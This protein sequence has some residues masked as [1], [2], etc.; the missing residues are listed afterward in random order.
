MRQNHNRI[1]DETDEKNQYALLS[2]VKRQMVHKKQ[3]E[4]L[5]WTQIALMWFLWQE[6]IYQKIK[7]IQPF[8]SRSCIMPY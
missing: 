3:W 7:L 5:P 4:F 6:P 8:T 1:D 2:V